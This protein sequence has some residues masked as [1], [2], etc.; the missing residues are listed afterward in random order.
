[1]AET[2]DTLGDKDLLAAL[3]AAEAEDLIVLADHITDAGKGRLALASEVKAA[4]LDAKSRRKFSSGALQLLVREVQH[5]GGNSVTNLFRRNGVPYA[6]V[7]RDVLE[8]L[9]GK[10][11][12]DETAQSMELKVLEQLVSSAWDKMDAAQRAELVK[13]L[14]SGAGDASQSAV[15]AAVRRG[16]PVALQAALLVSSAFVQMSLGMAGIAGTGATLVGGRAVGAFLGPIGIALSGVWGA[17]SLTRQAYRVTVPC[18]VQIAYIRQKQ[19]VK[20]CPSCEMGNLQS[21]K[22]CSECGTGLNL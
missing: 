18:V 19:A 3:S 17:Y 11:G 5:F 20:V 2:I 1:M 21:A 4:L 16:G 14:G 15:L 8:H 12:A 6:E 22:F 13:S 9:G 7:V 10:A